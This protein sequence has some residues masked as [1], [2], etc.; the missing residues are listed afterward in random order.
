MPGGIAGTEERRAAHAAPPPAPAPPAPAPA[1]VLPVEEPA[2]EVAADGAEPAPHTAPHDE[3]IA[4]VHDLIDRSSARSTTLD[5][6]ANALKSRGF[7]RTPGSPRLITRLRRIKEVAVSRSGVI[8]LVGERGGGA[9]E[10][11]S[12]VAEPEPMPFDEGPD[13]EPGNE[14][15][16]RIDEEPGNEAPEPVDEGPGPGNE[17]IPPAPRS[18]AGQQRRGRFRRGGRRRRP[19]PQPARAG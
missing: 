10:R 9:A 2:V 12:G 16:E 14:A 18:P 7:S 15:P 19:H 11:P 17:A 6:L 3:I 13:A 4:I 5:S 8:T 1:P